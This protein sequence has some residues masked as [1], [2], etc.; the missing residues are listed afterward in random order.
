MRDSSAKMCQVAD[1]ATK[2]KSIQEHILS[3]FLG[4]SVLRPSKKAN[5]TAL[6]DSNIDFLMI[7]PSSS[8]FPFPTYKPSSVEKTAVGFWP[9]LP[10]S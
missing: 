1:L 5:V 6:I 3:Q 4:A 10:P 7:F 9:V 2:N 8:A